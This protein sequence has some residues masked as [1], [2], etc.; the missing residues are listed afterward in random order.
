MVTATV[1]V[2]VCVSQLLLFSFLRVFVSAKRAIPSLFLFFFL[3]VPHYVIL[4]APFQPLIVSFCD[5]IQQQCVKQDFTRNP[6]GREN[7][8]NKSRSMKADLGF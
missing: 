6:L 3:L 8:I 2:C 7:E 5:R 1:C 4:I